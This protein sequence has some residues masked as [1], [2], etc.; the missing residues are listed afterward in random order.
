MNRRKGKAEDAA[1][2][3][4]TSAGWPASGRLPETRPV[5]VLAGALTRY[6]DCVPDSEAEEDATALLALMP[7]WVLMPRTKVTWLRDRADLPPQTMHTIHVDCGTTLVGWWCPMCH[8]N[9][10]MQSTALIPV[11]P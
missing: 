4:L 5:V 10:D 3:W 8:L 6:F 1:E 11:E 2:K 9:P 7:D